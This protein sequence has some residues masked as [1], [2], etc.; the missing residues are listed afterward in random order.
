MAAIRPVSSIATSERDPTT[1]TMDD[2]GG[3]KYPIH[4]GS[5]KRKQP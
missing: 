1:V 2:K 4:I 5:H 3:A